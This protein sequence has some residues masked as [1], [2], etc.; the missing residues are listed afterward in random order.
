MQFISRSAVRA[1]CVLCVALA[2]VPAQVHAASSV[3]KQLRDQYRGHVLLI[4]NF[5]PGSHLKYDSSGA[6]AFNATPGDWTVDGFVRINDVQLGKGL[7]LHGTRLL[8]VTGGKEFH[9]LKEKK[10]PPL[11]ID[12]LLDSGSLTLEQ[13]DA[14]LSRIFLT[15]ADR[16]EDAVPGH[17]RPCFTTAMVGGRAGCH[18]SAELL[19]V[20]GVSNLEAKNPEPMPQ[21]GRGTKPP[22]IRRQDD[23]PFTELARREK[24]QG[25]VI[26]RLGVDATGTPTN[27][28]IVIPIGGGLDEQ[29]RRSVQTWRFSPAEKDGKPVPTEIAVE[30]NFHLY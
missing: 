6:P 27:I 11:A 16:L 28:R 17:W 5:Y 15:T 23:P 20:P 29:A 1:A 22:A 7:T 21:M 14:A 13:A 9:F 3:E 26:L 18:F 2:V 19:A 8:A 12:T 10:G 25:T 4:R 30:V 24:I